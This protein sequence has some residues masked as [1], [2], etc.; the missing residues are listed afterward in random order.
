MQQTKKQRGWPKGRPR[1]KKVVVEEPIDDQTDQTESSEDEESCS[2]DGQQQEY[3][4]AKV[5]VYSK[6]T[7]RDDSKPASITVRLDRF[8]A[9]LLSIEATLTRLGAAV[10]RIESRLG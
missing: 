7:D 2:T 1:G 10:S 5:W 6:T 9:K 8:E 4:T 3:R